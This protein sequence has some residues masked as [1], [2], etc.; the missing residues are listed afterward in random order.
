MHKKI[1]EDLTKDCP[2][3][4]EWCFLMELASHMGDRQA[5]QI[6]LIYDYKYMK[7]KEEG[8]NIGNERA[9][10]EFIAQYAK[11]FCEVYQEDLT[12]EELFMKVFQT[13]LV[14]ITN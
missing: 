5:E 2:C 4:G 13:E 14:P 10:K 3:K 6:R 8:K 12:H 7:S 9:A 11:R 1:L